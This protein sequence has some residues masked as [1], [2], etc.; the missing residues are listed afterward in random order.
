MIFK[1]S[2]INPFKGYI[3]GFMKM[4]KPLHISFKR[5][6]ERVYESATYGKPF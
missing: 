5:V 6:Y 1:N 2:L 3:E 4:E